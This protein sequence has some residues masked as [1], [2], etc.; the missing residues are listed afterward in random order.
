MQGYLV[1]LGDNILGS[2]DTISGPLL[3]FNTASTLGSG[4]W[5]WSGTATGGATVINSVSTG[6]YYLGTDGSVYF[7]PSS[8]IG[9]L[10]GATATAT[11]SYSDITY[12]TTA[13]DTINGDGG[14]DVIYGGT[15]S[16]PTTSTGADTIKAGAGADTVFG[17]D[18]NDTISGGGGA[19][20]LYGGSGNDTI[21]GDEQT[22]LSSKHEFLHWTNQGRD[23]ANLTNGFTQDTGT[24]HVTVNFHN[25]G[26]NTA[27]EVTTDTQYVAAGETFATR[28]GLFLAGSGGK[29]STTTMQFDA[30]VGSGMADAVQNLT[31]RINDVDTGGWQD[32]ITVK[33]YDENG[34][35]L[36]VTLT[37][38]G[39]DTVSGNKITAG[40]GG[41]TPNSANGSVLVTV[42]GQ[43]H[44]IEIVYDNGGNST[45][46]LYITDVHYDTVV[47]ADGGD[48][49]DGGTGADIV[50][51]GGGDDLIFVAQG[52]TVY[53]ES[54]NDTFVLQD[55][56]EAGSATITIVGG[57]TGENGVGDTLK[58]NGLAKLS[59]V[60]ITDPVSKSG[61]VNLADGSRVNFSEIENI[62][63]FVAGAK[64]A[65]P[66]GAR[67]VETLAPGDLVVT[68][69]HGLQPLRWIGQR[70]VSGRGRFAPVRFAAGALSAGSE[71]LTVS[72]QHRVLFT[73]YRS[74]LLFGESEVLVPALHL[75]DGDRICRMPSAEVTYFHLLFDEHEIIFAEGA[76]SES[77][78]PGEQGLDA[79]HDASRE[80]LFSIFPELRAMPRSY[81]RAARRSL[82]KHEA[83][84][85]LA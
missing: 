84:L 15:S 55:L 70:T 14:S 20:K 77:F 63:C 82:R 4:S 79:L 24:M 67:A 12:G 59:D 7:V 44:S 11:P 36:T 41:D 28:S 51:G 21:Y 27:T 23:G 47:P 22:P 69:D 3:G 49:I 57:E 16:N 85:L 66:Y 32:I 2:G 10:S 62:I 71:A 37:P 61:H 46:N 42:S 64:I 75:I 68:R 8:P 58:L 54:G 45:Q 5:T 35:P 80:E 65:T 13:G 60:V 48:T 9:S 56:G 78:H 30:E 19:D 43:V 52:D 29:N 83:G 50:H 72:P 25:D 26:N 38:A 34:N 76:A 40:P 74:E 33:A 81:G 6:T 39:N 31:F 73:G 18:G 17:G 53:G 1:T